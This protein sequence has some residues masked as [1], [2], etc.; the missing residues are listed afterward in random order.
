MV[1]GS[2]IS[3][4]GPYVPFMWAGSALATIGSGLLYSLKANPERGTVDGFQFLAGVGLGLCNQISYNVTQYKLSKEKLIMGSTVVSFC[5]SLGPVL[6]ANVAQAI[7]ATS[8]THALDNEP[9]VEAA[10][11]IRA[12]PTAIGRTVPLA[13][14]GLVKDAYNY[15]LTRA[16]IPSIICGGLAF[17]CSLAMPWGNVRKQAT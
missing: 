11:I 14:Q 2:L 3:F 5:N 12:G 7:F 17:C 15:A 16:F 13:L 8:L 4:F 6:G 10:T 9:Q 1:S